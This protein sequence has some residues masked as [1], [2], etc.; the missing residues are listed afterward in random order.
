M[1]W[2][3][4][5]DLNLNFS[6]YFY[7]HGPLS[8]EIVAISLSRFL[9]I[10]ERCDSHMGS[11]C[12][13]WDG[14]TIEERWFYIKFWKKKQTHAKIWKQ[15]N[16]GLIKGC[17]SPSGQIPNDLAKP[18]EVWNTRSIWQWNNWKTQFSIPASCLFCAEDVSCAQMFEFLLLK[19]KGRIWKLDSA[20]TDSH[21]PK[22]LT[23]LL[24]WT[25][26]TS[27]WAMVCYNSFNVFVL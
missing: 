2:V 13:L 12:R 8:E 9:L 5:S 24:G 7:K 4:I 25:C 20:S 18:A 23:L 17:S 21:H 22:H 10:A 14:S 27:T 15:L 1:D 6:T 11:V 26:F 16:Q 19:G 3:T